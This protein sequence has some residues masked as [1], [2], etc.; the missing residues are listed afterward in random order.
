MFVDQSLSAIALTKGNILGKILVLS[1][2][3]PHKHAS[4]PKISFSCSSVTVY[5]NISNCQIKPYSYETLS[6]DGSENVKE[7]LLPIKLAMGS[8]L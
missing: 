2:Y 7:A 3:S 1:T 8:A 4:P 6:T 5:N